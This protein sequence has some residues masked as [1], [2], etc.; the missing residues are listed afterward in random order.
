MKT[1]LTVF[2]GNL[3]RTALIRLAISSFEDAVA[4]IEKKR[5]INKIFFTISLK[6]K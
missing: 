5:Q 4:L 2:A 3:D 6:N 1:P